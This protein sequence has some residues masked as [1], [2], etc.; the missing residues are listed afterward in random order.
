MKNFK[1]L[2]FR[3]IV[4]PFVIG[5]LLLA[6]VFVFLF[7]M[8]SYGIAKRADG[9]IEQ[10]I[11]SNQICVEDSVFSKGIA[12][13]FVKNENGIAFKKTD[14]YFENLSDKLVETALVSVKEKA[15]VLDKYKF[16]MNSKEIVI[17]GKAC[18]AFAIYDYTP[19]YDLLYELSQVSVMS[20]FLSLIILGICC[21]I[22]SVNAIRPLK[23]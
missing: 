13:S 17:D 12:M 18:V 1:R 8:T 22:M 7:G 2:Q 21:Y 16:K 6:G 4:T 10:T 15:F 23:D 3:Y 11:Q 14:K 9:I 20:Y 5:G 19:E